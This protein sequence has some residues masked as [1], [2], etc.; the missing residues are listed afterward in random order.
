MAFLRKASLI[1][2]WME[3][4]SNIKK[5]GVTGKRMSWVEYFHN[6]NKLPGADYSGLWRNEIEDEL[7]QRTSRSVLFTLSSYHIFRANDG[8]EFQNVGN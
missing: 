3:N 4:V 8:K 7:Q 5:L 1:K 6:I 2:V